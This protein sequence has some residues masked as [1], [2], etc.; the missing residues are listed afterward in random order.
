MLAV[1][2]LEEDGYHLSVGPQSLEASHP[3]AQLGPKQ[4]GIVYHTDISGVISAAIVESLKDTIDLQ[5]DEAPT[6]AAAVST[7]AHDAYLRGRY[8]LAQR[9]AIGAA[10]EFFWSELCDWYLELSKPVLY[11]ESSTEAQKRGTRRTLLR[12]LETGEVVR[13][14]ANETRVTDVRFISATNHDLKRAVTDERFREDLYFRIKGAEIHVPP[15]RAR[16]EDIPRLTNHFIG[17]F[18]AELE[19]GDR[20]VVIFSI[21]DCLRPFLEG[22][23]E[24]FY[25]DG[26][27]TC[28]RRSRTV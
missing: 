17:R 15:L 28:F 9:N 27:L 5:V 14:G 22:I 4:M 7:E 16:R 2:H 8:L 24:V 10:R 6:T 20:Q 26:H 3:L 21:A 19:A 25:R 12:V 1:A 23:C 11:E 13:L 18:A